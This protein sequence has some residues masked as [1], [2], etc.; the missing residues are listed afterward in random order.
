MN[1]TTEQFL[2]ERGLNV[3]DWVGNATSLKE[4]NLSNLL[5]EYLRENIL[6]Y[7]E[8]AEEIIDNVYYYES[9]IYHKALKALKP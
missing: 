3:I 7:K 4:V 6:D 5:N 8:L 2:K 9:P 1:K